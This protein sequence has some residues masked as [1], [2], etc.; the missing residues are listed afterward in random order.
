MKVNMLPIETQAATG[1]NFEVLVTH[2]DLTQAAANTTQA[3]TFPIQPKMSVELKRMVLDVP[4]EDV[5][6]AA[7]LAT[8]LVVGDA[9]SA[10]RYLTAT[11]LNVNGAEVLLKAGTGTIFPYTVADSVILSFSSMAAKNLAAL[12]KGQVRL[13]FAIQDA[14]S[15]TAAP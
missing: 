12:T 7:H 3:L 5:A 15:L 10:N 13:Q 8:G 14:R 2:A 1:A 9:G 6:D 4:F 11:E